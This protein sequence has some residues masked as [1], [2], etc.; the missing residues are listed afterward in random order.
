MSK[1]LGI[2]YLVATPIGN[3]EDITLRALR[4]LKEVDLIAAEDTR[5][6]KKLLT[7]FEIAT[8]LTSYHQHNL[9]SK[10]MQLLEKLLSGTHIALITDA[11]LP[12]IS[13]PGSHLVQMAIKEGITIVPIPGANA[14]LTGLVASGI[15]TDR[16]LFHGFLPRKKQER[17]KAL[18]ELALE[19]R[20]I[21]VYEAPHRLKGT[22]EQLLP[23]WQDRQVVVARELTKKFEEFVRGTAAQALEHFKS[24]EPRGEITLILEGRRPGEN[25][26]LDGEALLG[27]PIIQQDPAETVLEMVRKGDNKKE[28]IKIVSKR[29]GLGRRELYQRV[30]SAEGKK[31]TLVD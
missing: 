28:A 22:L 27:E 9:E 7:H 15:N 14:A 12:G 5:N 18:Q 4:I 21:I 23:I 29:L 17:A 19:P 31:A 24:H 3:L 13:D 6:S 30:L 2:L 16:F 26:A 10:G 20:T 8:P 11:G 1:Q 25:I